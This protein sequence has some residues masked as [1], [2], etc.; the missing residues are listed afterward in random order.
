MMRRLTLAAS[1]AFVAGGAAAQG[2]DSAGVRVVTNDAPRSV[3]PLYRV[4]PAPIIDL[5]AAGSDDEFTAPVLT[6]RLADGRVVVA[7]GGT[8]LRFYD[9]A[10]KRLA[11]FG[12]KGGGPGEFERITRLAVVRGDT[13][14]VFDG[15]T[16]RLTVVSPRA[17]L[18]RSISFATGRRRFVG[19]FPGPTLLVSATGGGGPQ[20]SGLYRDTAAY[21][22]TNRAGDSLGVVGRFPGRE[23]ILDIQTKN[24]QITSVN[25]SGLPFGREGLVGVADSGVVV[26]PMDRYELFRYDQ[27]GRLRQVIRRAFRPEPPTAADLDRLVAVETAGLPAGQENIR[28][29]RRA[30]YAKAPLPKAK[31]PYDAVVARGSE[32]WVRD[33][34]GLHPRDQPS[35]WSVFDA[36]GGWLTTV[37]TPAGFE[38]QVIGADFLL[39]TWLDADDLP[40]VRLLRLSQAR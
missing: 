2:R 34:H 16:A 38:P 11:T 32:L 31:P 12:R 10:G 19:A 6:A 18:V 27:S 35:R 9:P 30:S 39:G 14:L 25:I 33:Y 23:I 8:E 20:E 7:N 36:G 24:K 4:D 40:H 5:G 1:L 21:L 17:T 29:A 26:A 15:G 37:D 13:V 22:V 28:E 3:R